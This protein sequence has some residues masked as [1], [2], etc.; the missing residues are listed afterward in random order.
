MA[1]HSY[2]RSAHRGVSAN[3][4]RWRAQ[5]YVG[6]RRHELGS[7]AT[8]AEAARAYD[9]AAI[10][11]A[12]GRFFFSYIICTVLYYTHR[13]ALTHPCKKDFR[14]LERTLA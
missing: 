2:K 14:R 11:C 4:S 12:P 8:E 13:N 7:F 10:K 9:L 6:G 1:G 3:W 5:I